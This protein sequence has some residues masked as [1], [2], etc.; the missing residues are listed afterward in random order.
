MVKNFPDHR[1]IYNKNLMMTLSF[2]R[3]WDVAFYVFTMREKM[4]YSRLVLTCPTEKSTS[5]VTLQFIAIKDGR[6]PHL[7]WI[8]P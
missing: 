6:I 5:R 8:L 2:R 1:K 3:Y 4:K 7:T